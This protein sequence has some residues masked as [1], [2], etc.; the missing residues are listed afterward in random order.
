[1]LERFINSLKSTPRPDNEK[2][3][4]AQIVKTFDSMVDYLRTSE[5]FPNSEINKLST[6][7][8][9]LIGNK[10][11]LVALD[12]SGNIPT[13]SFAVLGSVD[14]Q[15]PIIFLPQN[16]LDQV[17]DN[18]SVQLGAIAFTASQCKDYF[19]GNVTGSNGQEIQTRAY[20]NEAETL[21]TMSDIAK[22]EG[23]TL[24]FTEYQNIV[25]TNFPNGLECLDS[26]I[27]YPTPEYNTLISPVVR[28]PRKN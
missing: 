6:L 12:P 15:T 23:V 2:K 26:N 21:K 8:W 11:I 18:P 27:Q 24:N 28:D 20:A 25:L 7:M 13:I 5:N 14:N 16:F 1:M 3:E 10:H 17:R 9:R 22:S 19:M 4:H